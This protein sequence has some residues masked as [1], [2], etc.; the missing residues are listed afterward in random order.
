MKYKSLAAAVALA[1]SATVLG[2]GSAQAS[3]AVTIWKIGTKT[4]KY[5]KPTYLLKPDVFADYGVKVDSKTLTVKRGKKSIAR[6]RASVK[7]RPGTYK[8]TTK[9]RYRTSKDV[10]QNVLRVPAGQPLYGMSTP[11]DLFD[12]YMSQCRTTSYVSDTDFTLNCDVSNATVTT[13]DITDDQV[14]GYDR[15]WDISAVRRRGVVYLSGIIS[16]VNI[17]T[18]TEV[19][20]F[21]ATKTKTRTQTMR[22]EKGKKPAPPAKCA[23]YS[24]YERVYDGD[25][26]GEVYRLLGPSKVAADSGSFQIREYKGCKKY[27][28]FSVS[29]EDSKV[30][31]KAYVG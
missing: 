12:P 2:T 5:Q 24:N 26:T 17:V 16:P 15:S 19:T 8:V 3:S 22:V 9:V 25:T 31:G 20:T 11:H 30:V 7:L 29:F 21:S 14:L 13:V 6:N 18:P 4:T 28:Y 27:T 1:V 23:T 10:T